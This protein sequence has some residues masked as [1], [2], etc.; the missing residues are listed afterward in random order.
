MPHHL[1][2]FTGRGEFHFITFSC[3]ERRP[4]LQNHSSKSRFL[5]ILGQVRDQTGFHLAGYVLMPEH[6]H[7]LIDEPP[8]SSPAKVIQILKQRVSRTIRQEFLRSMDYKRFWQRRY[9]DF[10]VHSQ[11]KLQEKLNYMHLN[12]V[13]RGLVVHPRDWLWSSW[14]FYESGSGLLPIDLG[15]TNPVEAISLTLEES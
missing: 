13:K 14:S 7:L 10:N 1:K 9:F 2:R 5:E 3:Y 15:P 8:Q 6:V 4:F 12:P 11:E